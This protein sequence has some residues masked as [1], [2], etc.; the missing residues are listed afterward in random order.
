MKRWQDWKEIDAD[1]AKDYI[2][3]ME[4]MTPEPLFESFLMPAPKICL[5][6]A[7]ERASSLLY[8]PFGMQPVAPLCMRC[9][10]DWNFSSYAIFKRL[11]AKKLLWRLAK[12]KMKH[13]FSRPSVSDVYQDLRNL[14][15]WAN[16]MKRLRNAGA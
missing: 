1:Y 8:S 10:A 4:D 16:K 14:L 15:R 12:F 6:C 2:Q 7:Q 3:R 11:P 13:P 9:A 5:C